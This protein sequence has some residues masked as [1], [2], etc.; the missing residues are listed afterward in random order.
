MRKRRAASSLAWP[1][2]V[3][4]VPSSSWLLASSTSCC[5][6]RWLLAP[7]WMSPLTA[8]TSLRS[9]CKALALTASSAPSPRLARVRAP[10]VAPGRA[11]MRVPSASAMRR[12]AA[13]TSSSSASVRRPRST[14]TSLV[15]LPSSV[16]RPPTVLRVAPSSTLPAP[17]AASTSA[18][19]PKAPAG[20]CV[21][22]STRASRVAEKS[23]SPARP[24]VAPASC[25]PACQTPRVL[26]RTVTCTLPA[27]RGS[28]GVALPIVPLV[29]LVLLPLVVLRRAR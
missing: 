14:V 8:A 12:C 22:S 28:A 16:D 21:A 19:T 5:P 13:S 26:P 15:A 4:P 2:S 17:L 23:S 20:V 29:P 18:L 7:S 25:K 6:A 3:L 11:S 27:S 1:A 24:P 9:I 10:S